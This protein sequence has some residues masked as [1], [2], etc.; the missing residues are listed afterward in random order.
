MMLVLPL[1]LVGHGFQ[2][3]CGWEKLL[4]PVF[5]EDSLHDVLSS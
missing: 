1:R 5:I 3:Y 2:I 4:L